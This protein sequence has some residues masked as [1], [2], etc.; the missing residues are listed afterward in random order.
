[1]ASTIPLY[2]WLLYAALVL[3]SYCHP[4][5]SF[6]TKRQFTLKRS[7]FRSRCRFRFRH[8]S[9]FQIKSPTL[10]AVAN[11]SSSSSDDSSSSSGKK[12]DQSQKT[13]VQA[14][15]Q[16]QAAIE[17]A[18]LCGTLKT[19][20]RRGWMTRKVPN[21]ESVAD[22]SWRVAILCLLLHTDGTPNDMT[23]NNNPNAS[24]TDKNDT[25]TNDTAKSS[26]SS[27]PLNVSKCMQMAVVHDLAEA[28][29]GDIAPCDNISPAEKHALEQKAIHSIAQNLKSVGVSP[30]TTESSSSSSSSSSSGQSSPSQLRLLDLYNEYEERTSNEAIVVKD[31][32]LLEMILQAREYETMHPEIDLEE[33]WVGTPPSR[34]Q[35]DWIRAIASELHLERTRTGTT[36]TTTTRNNNKECHDD[37]V[38]RTIQRRMEDEEQ[39]RKERNAPPQASDDSLPRRSDSDGRSATIP[40]S[41]PPPPPSP[42][43]PPPPSPLSD[44][45]HDFLKTYCQS[46][47]DISE[48]NVRHVLLALRDF[49]NNNERTR[50]SV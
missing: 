44:L 46:R 40:S 41:P 11:H 3:L 25:D 38:T 27:S 29:V 2:A 26:S 45:D 13:H 9:L 42:P 17:F 28:I 43:P 5:L 14:Q 23:N 8:Q 37:H 10:L 32:D 6:S 15:A 31:L 49:N 16:A 22:H 12:K 4:A 36:T 7:R 20:K 21:A 39:Q 47:P 48:A 50:T 24:D 18:T 34:F 33:F 30:S 19:T 35:N 1:M